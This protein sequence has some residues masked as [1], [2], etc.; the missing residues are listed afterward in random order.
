MHILILGGTQF[1]G[2]HIVEAALAR[3]HSVTLFNRG[4]TNADL[5]P[6]VEKVIGDRDGGLAPLAGRR[7]DGVIDVNGYVPRLV[8]DSAEFLRDS[9]DHYTFIS[10][11]SVYDGLRLPAD[12]DENAPLDHSL[13]D[14]TSEDVPAHY[15]ALKVLCEQAVDA[16]FDGR[17]AHVRPGIVAGP[18]DPTD[19][20]TYW[21]DRIARGGTLLA[22]GVPEQPFQCIDARDLAA[23]T[24]HTVEARLTG[25]FNAVG[26][27]LTWQAFLDTARQALAS[28]VVAEWVPDLA[29]VREHV[30]G[31]PR[32]GGVLPMVI[33]DP[34]YQNL[35]RVGNARAVAHGLAPRPPADTFR[36][37]QAWVAGRS[38]ETAWRAGLSAE[39]ERAVLQA[40][41]AR[42]RA[43]A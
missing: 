14:P 40:W 42:G 34:A 37:T 2:R 26:P 16:A 19:R 6:E 29:F 38:A 11:I 33:G 10:T 27:A 18:H 21:V 43:A 20:V 23:F 13:D 30:P 31:E 17:S 36:A 35:F 28:D 5:F 8:R 41:R 3:G 15:G 32:P 1:V 22:P 39:Q 7:W 25:P 12:G 4:R 9:A 24:V